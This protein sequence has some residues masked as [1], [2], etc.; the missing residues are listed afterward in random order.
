M[1]N[2]MEENEYLIIWT[3]HYAT[4][5]NRAINHNLLILQYIT[6]LLHWYF[7][8]FADL[9]VT[10]LVFI[11]PANHNSSETAFD[12]WRNILKVHEAPELE[13][14]KLVS[15]SGPYRLQHCPGPSTK[16]SSPK[17][18][19]FQEALDIYRW[20]KEGLWEEVNN[21]KNRAPA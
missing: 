5:N 8:S 6:F 16:F 4:G 3:Y 20:M 10:V 17:C 15:Y 9:K 2:L 7:H 19:I 13:L 18:Q 14:R 21:K 11:K 1:K 12:T